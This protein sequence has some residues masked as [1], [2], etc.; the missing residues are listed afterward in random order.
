MSNETVN[1]A[2]GTCTVVSRPWGFYRGARL[3]C[4]DGVVRAAKRIAETADTFFSVPASVTVHGKTVSGYATVECV[5]GSSVWTDDD[6]PMVKFIAYQYGKNANE[7]PAGAWKKTI[8]HDYVQP[9]GDYISAGCDEC[10]H[11][12]ERHRDWSEY[13]QDGARW[14]KVNN[15]DNNQE[16]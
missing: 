15:N 2:E 5:S 3:M 13:R 7:L 16:T 8:D 1:Y 6:P 11:G 4:S 12:V 14:V 9:A 10:G